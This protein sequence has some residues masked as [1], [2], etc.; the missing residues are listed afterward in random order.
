MNITENS[1]KFAKEINRRNRLFKNATPAQKRVLIAKDVLKQI[2]QKKISP[3]N[4]IFMDISRDTLLNFNY[5]D[6]FQKALIEG[7]IPPCECCAQGAMFISCTLFNNQTKIYDILKYNNGDYIFGGQI[8]DNEII[9]NKLNQIF[10]KNQL[11]L[12][13]IAF[14]KGEGYFTCNESY[15]NIP[16]SIS[17]SK[18]LKA[19]NFFGDDDVD[20]EERMIAIMKN[21]IKNK[22]EFIP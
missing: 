20:S 12:I 18:Y 17:K 22:G 2:K 7:S 5:E 6:S 10:S 16:K 21:I 4:G 13:E 9:S 14:E 11:I 15:S 1:N 3:Q 19:K 8:E